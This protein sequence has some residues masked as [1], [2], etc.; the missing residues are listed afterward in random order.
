MGN[1]TTELLQEGF[2]SWS[3]YFCKAPYW[4][5]AILDS[6]EAAVQW[7]SHMTWKAVNPIV[8]PVEGI[9][10]KGIKVL[11]E[12]LEPYLSFWQRSEDLPKWDVTII[13]T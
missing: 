3:S 5:G 11:T 2:R 13:P 7:A 1:G 8:Y 9:Y 12:D 6:E 4:N 10:E